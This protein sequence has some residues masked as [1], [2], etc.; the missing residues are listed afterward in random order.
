VEYGETE[1]LSGK[2]KMRNLSTRNDSEYFNVNELP[3]II[4]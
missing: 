4:L 2:I 1:K 3:N